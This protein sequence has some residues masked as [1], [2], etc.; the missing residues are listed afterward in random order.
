[1]LDFAASSMLRC[2]LLGGR[3][4]GTLIHTA[5]LS[6]HES[7]LTGTHATVSAARTAGS[8]NPYDTIL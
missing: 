4:E 1:M 8:Y 5:E 3:R 7:R 6:V 2:Y